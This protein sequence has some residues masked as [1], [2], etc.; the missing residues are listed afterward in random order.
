MDCRGDDNSYLRMYYEKLA[1]LKK[2]KLAGFPNRLP[3]ELF[4]CLE[5]RP[6][7][8]AGKL[9]ALTRALEPISRDP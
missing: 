9:F 8:P 2:V 7:A 5:K 1:G 4:A 6:A 3:A